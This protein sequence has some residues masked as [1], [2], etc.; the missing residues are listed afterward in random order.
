M[1]SLECCS[2]TTLLA[3]GSSAVILLLTYIPPFHASGSSAVI[4]LLTY[5]PPFHASGSSAVIL[6]LTYIPPFHAS[7]SSAVIFKGGCAEIYTIWDLFRH[8]AMTMYLRQA[9]Y[10][11]AHNHLIAN[12]FNLLFFINFFKTW[13]PNN[14]K[15]CIPGCL[16]AHYIYFLPSL[17]PPDRLDCPCREVHRQD[18]IINWIFYIMSLD[19]INSI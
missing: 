10:N 3:S 5:I 7:G 12:N 11:S 9:Q 4:L 1:S 2:P 18:C 14:F 16:F 8:L 19:L 17:Q 6:L 15:L 13:T